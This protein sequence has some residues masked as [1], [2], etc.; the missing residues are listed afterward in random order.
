M[1]V[2]PGE[3]WKAQLEEKIK[4]RELF[5]LFWSTAASKSH[6]V[7]WE[8]HTALRVRGKHA[9]QIHPLEVGIQAPDE[10][11]ELHFGDAYMLARN[12]YETQNTERLFK[13]TRGGRR[14]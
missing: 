10:L 8:W 12:A 1:P 11:K 6:W 14:T 2:H 7:D 3:A 9:M 5:L 4:E 13:P